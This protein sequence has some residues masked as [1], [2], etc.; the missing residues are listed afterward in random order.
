[1]ISFYAFEIVELMT[2]ICFIIVRRMIEVRISNIKTL[3]KL[4]ERILWQYK[5]HL[6]QLKW[7]GW[8]VVSMRLVHIVYPKLAVERND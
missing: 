5:R 3:S 7:M 2:Y 8:V 4:D 6:K 1:M